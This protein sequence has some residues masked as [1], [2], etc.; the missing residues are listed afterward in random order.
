MPRNGQ[1]RVG[2]P[3]MSI[4]APS[5]ILSIDRGE[6]AAHD[7]LRPHSHP[8]P[9]LFW[10]WT[11]TVLVTAADRDWLVPPGYGVWVPGGV[12]HGGAVLRAGE[13]FAITFDPATCPIVWSRPT[14]VSG[15][16]LLRELIA[17]LHRSDGPRGRPRT[18]RLGRLHT[19][20]PA[21]PDPP[22]PERDR[23]QLHPLARPGPDTRRHPDAERGSDRR[24]G[25]PARRVPEDERLHRG[26]PA[27]H[28]PDTRR[29]PV[30][31]SCLRI[32]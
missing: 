17:H 28:R 10:T 13:G 32:S 18:H 14:G 31:T 24:I 2:G 4:P 12:E 5:P 30:R 8:E 29:L 19:Y 6:S 23:S 3:E 9:K 26:L 27:R 25:G 22:L 1:G 7:G 21:D 11:A 20:G 16:P 15:G